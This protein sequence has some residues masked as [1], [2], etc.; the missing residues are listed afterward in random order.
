MGAT[1]RDYPGGVVDP[2][3]EIAYSVHPFFKKGTTIAEWNAN[4]GNLAAT[5]P[6]ILTAWNADAQDQWCTASTLNSPSTFLNYLEQRHIGVVGFAFDVK[7]TIVKN[8]AGSPTRW[9]NE[10][11]KPGG[12][13]ELL[14][15]HF[16]SAR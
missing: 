7:A 8:F 5:Q 12:P 13:G 10:C 6:V 11:G 2:D 14:K 15:A 3:N 16:G 9:P 4:F 1:F